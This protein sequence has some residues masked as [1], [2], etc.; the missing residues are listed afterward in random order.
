MFRFVP[1]LR[2]RLLLLMLFAV[3]PAI[4]I[5]A[6][7]GLVGHRARIQDAMGNAETLVKTVAS[8][9][10]NRIEALHNLL[11]TVTQIDAVQAGRGPA[12]RAQLA[13]IKKNNEHVANI[14]VI[15]PD[16][17]VSCSAVP[18]AGTV[19]LADRDYF[20]RAVQT[21]RLA[22]S[23]YI[24][25]RISGKSVLVVALPVVS[26]GAVRQVVYIG[27]DLAWLSRVIARLSLPPTTTITLFDK[28]GSILLRLP[29]RD[30]LVGTMALSLPQGPQALEY[31]KRGAGGRFEAPGLD[32]LTRLY[33]IVPLGA[34]D[35]P[36][37]YLSV[38]IA[39][40]DIHG[41]EHTVFAV[42]VVG[43][44]AS[45]LFTL[46]L[47]WFGAQPMLLRRLQ[48]VLATIRRVAAGDLGARTGLPPQDDDLGKLAV[49]VDAM[50]S[51]LQEHQHA[52]SKVNTALRLEKTRLQLSVDSAGIGFWEANLQ[53]G[54][55]HYS[56]EWKR[57]IGYEPEELDDNFGAWESRLHPN[58]HDRVM[59][60][61]L[62]Y[63]RGEAPNYD[64][65]FR[66][67]HRDGSWRWILSRGTLQHDDQGRPLRMIGVHIDITAIR[68]AQDALWHREEQLRSISAHVPGLVFR[69]VRQT[70]RA[71]FEFVSDGVSDLCGRRPEEFKELDH[72]LAL[73]V[74]A[75]RDGFVR[76]LDESLSTLVPINW[77]GRID[78]GELRKWINVRASARNRDGGVC[79]DGVMLNVTLIKRANDELVRAR[80]EIREL[81]MHQEIVREEEK[82]SIA[83]EIHD[84]LGATLTAI[85]MDAHWAGSRMTNA[86]K[87]I[88]QKLGDIRELADAAIQATRRISTELHPRV[89]DDLG[90]VAAIEWLTGEFARRYGIACRYQGPDHEV[91]IEPKRALALFRIL[92]ESLTNVARHAG[93][94][95]V[96]VSLALEGE[97]VRLCVHDNGGG[98][99]PGKPERPT[100]HG[101]RGMIERA[102]YFG[103]E[104]RIENAGQGACVTAVLPFGAPAQPGEGGQSS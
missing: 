100:A 99:S 2:A 36:Y 42:S 65:E 78:V 19:N 92:Q 37:A 9:H 8:T 11:Y 95:A 40:E 55:R 82:R 26:A 104:V 72:F 101:V 63:Q 69:I 34:V 47:V 33:T 81:T 77:E 10:A 14:G 53:T 7:L 23:R 80:D 87:A 73:V 97:G 67:Q 3:S 43:L 16:G 4:F 13:A 85:K 96:E 86:N 30:G 15:Q 41:K 60:A 20:Q 64:T 56:P 21:H 71:V 18:L 66:L 93:A 22:T 6:Y 46:A 79:W 51:T 98:L 27:L 12:C 59:L 1:G 84:E 90:L 17:R 29:A 49:E 25:G 48:P 102:R 70:G 62:Q 91:D 61:L 75:D 76:A 31:I 68:Q 50:A 39:E 83:R 38:G 58:D 28:E 32:G 57:Q 35:V 52:I 103:G 74:K 54:Q 5:I 89:L 94:T 24:H 44:M 88:A 45:L